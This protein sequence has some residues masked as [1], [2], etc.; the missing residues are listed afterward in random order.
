MNK[1]C[2]I[3]LNV[4]EQELELLILHILKYFHIRSMGFGVLVSYAPSSFDLLS[5]LS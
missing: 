5:G 2:R 4:R 1:H 3:S